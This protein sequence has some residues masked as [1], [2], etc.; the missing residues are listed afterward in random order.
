[1]LRWKRYNNSAL[2]ALD[3][4][5]KDT[6][7]QSMNLFSSSTH[8][9]VPWHGKIAVIYIHT[10]LYQLNFIFIVRRK[11]SAR[12]DVDKDADILLMVKAKAWTLSFFSTEN[13]GKQWKC[14]CLGESSLAGMKT[15][16]LSF[17]SEDILEV[18]I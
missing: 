7:S 15:V 1:M 8:L 16:L 5:L 9:H 2:D 14:P 10:E 12:F 3:L 17:S 4:D 11:M 6:S 18:E 13:G